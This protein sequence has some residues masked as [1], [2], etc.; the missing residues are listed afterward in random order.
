MFVCT[1]V[2]VCVSKY[3]C[4]YLSISIAVHL[5][6]TTLHKPIDPEYVLTNSPKLMSRR[7]G[8]KR[9]LGGGTKKW[10]S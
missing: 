4:L 10:G 3:M 6:N 5:R 9:R 1:C 8:K 7:R 2:C